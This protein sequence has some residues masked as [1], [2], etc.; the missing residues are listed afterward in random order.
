MINVVNLMKPQPPKEHP[1]RSDANFDVLFAGQADHV[2]AFG[3]P[4]LIHRLTYHGGRI[5]TNLRR[6][7]RLQGRHDDHRSTWWC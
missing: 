5:T 6:R 7:P 1:R 2:F 3:Y 4:W